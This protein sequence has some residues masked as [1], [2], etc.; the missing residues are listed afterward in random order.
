MAIEPVIAIVGG[1]ALVGMLWHAR[2]LVVSE[3]RY[4]ESKRTRTP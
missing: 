2:N 1:A 3:L 4:R